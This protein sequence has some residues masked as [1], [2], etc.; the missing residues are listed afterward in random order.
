MQ[1]TPIDVLVDGV[2][3]STHTGARLVDV[4]TD[5]DPDFP[6]VCYHPALGPIRTCDTCLV[7]VDGELVRSCDTVASEGQTVVTASALATS[8]RREAMDRILGNHELYCTL[9]DNNN[10]SCEVKGTSEALGI[11]HQ[12]YPF[13]KKGFEVDNSSPFYRY[14]ADQCIGCGRCVEACQNLQVNETLTIDWES[15]QPRVQWDGGKS[16][17]ESSCVSCGHC[18][19][20]CPCN[21]LMENTMIG[22]AGVFSGLPESVKRSGIELVKHLEPITGYSPVFALSTVESNIRNASIE[23]TKTVCTYCGVGCSFEVWTK[24]RDILKIEPKIEAPAN[25]ISTCV[26]GKFSWGHINSDSRLTTPLVRDG[27]TFK[28]V[29]WDEALSLIATR[30]RELQAAHGDDALAFIGSS[31]CTNEEAYLTQKLARAVFHTNNI[32]NCSRYCQAPATQGLWRTVGYGGDSGSISDIAA[33]DLV[34]VIGANAA[35]NHP[36]LATRVKRAQKLNGQTLIVAD[37]RKHELARRADVFFRPSPGSDLVWLQAVAKYILDNDLHDASFLAERVNNVD[38][39]VQSLSDYTLEYASEHTGLSVEVLTDVAE[40]IARAGSVCALWGMGVTQHHGGSNTS[41][42]IS[43]LLLVTGNYGRTGTGAYPLRGHNN[44]QGASD[45]GCVNTFLP[46]YQAVSDSAVRAKFEAAWG[47]PLSDVKGLDNHGMVEAIH[48]GSLKGMMVIGEEMS[49]VDANANYVQDA[50]TKLDFLVVQDIF[51]SRTAAFADVIL[52]GAPSLEKSGTFTS[53]ERRIQQLY[54]ALDPLGDSRADWVILCELAKRLGHAWDYVHP[55]EIMDEAAALTPLIAGVTYDRLNDFGS[56]QWP[57]AADGTDEPLLY[58]E[59][60]HFD[61][62][63][64]RLYPVDWLPLT[65]VVDDEYDLHLNNGRV[66]EH[67]HVTNQTQHTAGAMQKVPDTFVELCPELAQERDV[68]EGDWVRLVSRRGRVRVRVV[69]TDRVHRNELYMPMNST[70]HAINQL[71]SSVVDPDSGTPAYKECAV[72][73]EKLGKRGPPVLGKN[74][75]RNHTAT[76]Q[77]GV[78]VE[79]KWARPDYLFPGAK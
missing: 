23:R 28:P 50:L 43:N 7:E 2:R 76:P 70:D 18:V 16:I 58:T 1:Q 45:F 65:D 61:D 38:A 4:L 39:F 67:F 75:W 14:D 35:E 51:M 73:L 8:A 47:A 25:G 56:Q 48:D 49:L 55:S 71:T 10:G 29:S 79:R 42:A 27:E 69:V 19:T 37:L 36:V 20:V 21:A 3:T 62:G 24:G 63:K 6:H 30:F 32:D 52:P 64:A 53:T 40:R 44:V 22:E 74:N 41:T 46:G 17:D 5:V 15:P 72:K 59:R 31:K 26:K 12:R 77:T 60:F 34:L 66:L 68:Q 9:C 57:V 13:T 54:Q 33:A 78:E 11:E